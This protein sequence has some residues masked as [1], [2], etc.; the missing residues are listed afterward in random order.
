MVVIKHNKGRKERAAGKMKI[1]VTSFS[2]GVGRG[3]DSK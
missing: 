1:L 2:P 3:I